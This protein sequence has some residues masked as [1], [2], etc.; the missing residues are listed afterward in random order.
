[1]SNPGKAHITDIIQQIDANSWLIGDWILTRSSPPLPLDI[2]STSNPLGWLDEAENASYTFTY[3]SPPPPPATTLD[4]PYIK[5]TYDCSGGRAFFSIG[6]KVVC[7]IR[8]LE[9]F[10]ITVTSELD[11]LSY[12]CAKRPTSFTTPRI[13]HAFETADRSFLF[14][15]RVPGRTLAAAWRELSEEK[16]QSYAEAVVCAIKEMMG[17]ESS[18]VGG[19]DGKGIWEPYLQRSEED[20]FDV[21][22]I[23]TACEQLGMDMQAPFVFYHANLGPTNVLLLDG[24][25]PTMT[26][27]STSPPQPAI[28]IIDFEIAGFFPKDWIATKFSV[29]CGLN[30]EF[31]AEGEHED[32]YWWRRTVGRRLYKSGLREVGREYMKWQNKR[33]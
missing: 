15:T 24:P 14:M 9:H 25:G 19:I 6:T 8:Q 17:W 29:S 3:S 12:V 23:R 7:K 20:T 27:S 5:P 13:V 4:T 2:T 10:D 16:R 33:N 1:M 18:V 11:T 28:G 21:I 31:E 30:L 32:P 26:S 22:A